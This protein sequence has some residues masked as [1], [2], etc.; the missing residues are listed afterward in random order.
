ME[1]DHVKE[2]GQEDEVKVGRRSSAGRRGEVLAKRKR[3]RGSESECEKL[4]DEAGRQS[5]AGRQNEDGRQNEAGL[6]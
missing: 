6:N 3:V 2:G 1:A 5:R 4:V